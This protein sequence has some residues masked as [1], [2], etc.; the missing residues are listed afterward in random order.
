[1]TE[2]TAGRELDALIAEK[3]MGWKLDYEFADSIGAP[4]V[5]ALRDQYDEW[6]MLPEFSTDISAAWQV[7]KRLADSGFNVTISR[8]LDWRDK[9]ECYL[10]KENWRDDERICK[11]ADT[12]PLAIC[13]A[14][15]KAVEATQ[16]E[17]TL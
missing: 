5:P 8:V 10:V 17:Q 9:Y 11:G 7:V 14:A 1:M 2:L 15:L 13:L 4:T 6:G 16:K 12:A 3:V